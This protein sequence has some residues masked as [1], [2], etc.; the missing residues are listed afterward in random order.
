MVSLSTANMPPLYQR[1]CES[2]NMKES[3]EIQLQLIMN[4]TQDILCDSPVFRGEPAFKVNQLFS[5][6]P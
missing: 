1:H 3:D 6:S 5:S 4:L 2:V